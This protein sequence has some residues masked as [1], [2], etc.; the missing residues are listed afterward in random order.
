MRK[1]ICGLILF[2]AIFSGCS[3]DEKKI[4]EDTTKTVQVKEQAPDIKLAE[5]TEN[6]WLRK[7]LP[8]KAVLYLRLPTPWFYFTGIEN[9]FKYAQ[10]N[11]RHVKQ[12]EIIRQGVDERIVSQLEPAI[13][14]IASIFI[15]HLISPVE[16][17]A[18]MNEISPPAPIIMLATKLDF[19]TT[20]DFHQNLSG[21]LELTPN[22]QETEPIDENGYGSFMFPGAMTT[23]VYRFDPDTK[24]LLVV[25]GAGVDKES[26][27]SIL[28]GI[29]PV[30]SHAM[31]ELEMKIDTSEKGLFGYIDAKSILQANQRMIPPNAQVG[32]T[33]SGFDKM[34]A[35]AFGYGSSKGKSRLKVIVDMPNIGFRSYLPSPS[36][37]FDFN[38]RGSIDSLGVLALPT[39]AQFNNVESVILSTKGPFPE[40]TSFKQKFKTRTGIELG[41]IFNVIGPE[42]V[43]F[44]DEVSDFLA[45]HLNNPELFGQLVQKMVETGLIKFDEHKRGSATIKHIAVPSSPNSNGFAQLKEAVKDKPFLLI[46]LGLLEKID[47]HYYWIEED[48]YI[49]L[50]GVPQPLIER[51]LRND[52]VSVKSWLI[53]SQKHDMGSSILGFTTS[54]KNV[55]RDYYYTYLQLLRPLADISGSEVDFFAFPHAGELK[56]PERG[57]IGM[58]LDSSEKYLALEANFQESPMD[59]FF[60]GGTYQ[61]AA[62]A[63]ILAAI[64]IPQFEAYRVRSYNA[65]AQAD[66][67]NAATAQE[68]YYVDNGTYCDNLNILRGDN[69]GLFLSKGVELKILSANDTGYMMEAYNTKGN[70]IYSIQGPGGMIQNRTR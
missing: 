46:F 12:L 60:A 31:Y 37:S 67:R 34:N 65:A 3:S 58:S 10:Q 41:E 17:A 64:A 42:V 59:V 5:F 6:A 23:I 7:E 40:Y 49:I 21:L 24:K 2:I 48:G 62:V 9:G 50:A 52:M 35:L 45:V 68:A 19:E 16:V 25:T 33:M 63:G 32:L 57:S 55:S 47:T 38:A 28:T 27:H 29:K 61:T 39:Q 22:I 56:F 1:L 30:P 14:P 15:K 53:N 13:Q 11:E 69:Y 44:S 26:L 43:Y 70:M 54:K 36:N 18:V 51:A 66:L 8:E 20:G 4:G